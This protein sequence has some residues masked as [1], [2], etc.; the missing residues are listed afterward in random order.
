[1]NSQAAVRRARAFRAIAAS[2]TLALACCSTAAARNYLFE[3]ITDLPA[4]PGAGRSAEINDEGD[5]AFLNGEMVWFYDRGTNSFLDVTSLPGAPSNP[6]FVKLNNNG[7]IAIV[8]TPTTSRDLWLFEQETQAFTNI[9]ALPSYPGDS[10]ASFPLTAFDLNDNNQMSFHSGDNNFG[11]IYVYDHASGDFDRVTGMPDGPLRGRENEINNSGQVLYMGFPSTYLYDPALGTTTNINTLP[12]GP[13]PALTNLD[14]NDHGD[15]ALMSATVAQFYDA[16][17]GT[18]LDI[19]AAPGWPPNITASSRSDLGNSGDIT[20]WREGLYAFDTTTS[21]FSKLNGFP[22]G[23]AAGG[24][25]TDLNSSGQI[26]LTAGDD[27]YLAT[28]RPYGDHDNDGDV[29]GH[30]FLAW[31]RSESPDPLSA[32]D[33]A[34]WRTNFGAPFP[35]SATSTP[36]PEPSTAALLIIAAIGRR[37]LEPSRRQGTRKPGR[38]RAP[39]FLTNPSH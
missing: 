11:D 14:L 16:A 3:N 37:A 31:Q 33:L 22:G 20:F 28:P 26:A 19:A 25:E 30:D 12:G 5:V 15:V 18:F 7:D 23:P 8:E 27:I 10:F 17:T 9:S 36:V 1:M 29:D 38:P 6:F 24:T 4:G 13:G 34:D 39:R 32:I 35:A 2:M 21:R